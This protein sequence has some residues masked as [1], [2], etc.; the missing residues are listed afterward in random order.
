[1][2]IHGSRPSFNYGVIVTTR[3]SIRRELDEDIDVLE[4]DKEKEEEKM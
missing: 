2:R 4:A 3:K 1:M